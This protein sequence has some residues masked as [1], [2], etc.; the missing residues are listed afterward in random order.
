MSDYTGPS[1]PHWYGYSDFARLFS[2]APNS[3]SAADVVAD[4]GLVPPKNL[5]G[6]AR[7]L[8]L[9]AAGTLLRELKQ[10]T[11]AVPPDKIGRLGLIYTNR[12]G[13]KRR[14]GI[15]REPTGGHVPYVIEAHVGC[16][17]AD[18]R[19]DSGLGFSLTIN[20][21]A[22]PVEMLGGFDGDEFS[23]RGCGTASVIQSAGR[24][25]LHHAIDYHGEPTANI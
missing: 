14:S 11:P 6:P 20:K 18:K 17:R 8:T 24:Y 22:S 7:D 2:D 21:S 19:S 10:Q 13:Y 16:K 5:T 3:A 4:L 15:R 23:M 9:D 25:L 12:P 1:N